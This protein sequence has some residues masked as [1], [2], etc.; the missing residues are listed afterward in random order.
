MSYSK[1]S[2]T[3]TKEL[4]GEEKKKNGIYFTPPKC[5]QNNMKEIKTYKQTLNKV[6]EPSC[7]SCEYIAE[8]KKEYKEANIT[9]IEYNKFIYDKI[10][11]NKNKQLNL[12]NEDFLEYKT[13]EKYDLIIGN[14]PYY[15]MKQS[16]KTKEYKDYFDG[17]PNIFILFIIKSLQL[18]SEDG[19]LSFVLPRNF[20]NCVYYNKTREYISNNYKILSIQS[21]EGD[22]I[23]TQQDTIIL[24]VQ[25]T[26]TEI[27]N[28]KYVKQIDKYTIFGTEVIIEKLNNLYMNSKTLKQL[29]FQ[30]KVGNVTWNDCKEEL[31]DDNTK[32][33]I[34]YNADIKNENTEA[35]EF[36]N[37]D[38]KNY[39]NRQGKKTPT[40]LVNRGYGVGKYT[41]DYCI[42]NLEKEYLLENHV[43]YIDTLKQESKEATLEKY[44]YI[45]KSFEDERTKDFINLYFGNNAINTKEL[46]NIMPIYNF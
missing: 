38:K 34:I 5:I 35:T 24:N 42:L 32:T 8:I 1:L 26:E 23:E 9:G 41:F 43:L 15:V 14:P 7:G 4:S 17:R 30:V 46:E 11:A 13:M 19:I 3:I 16:K 20:L 31:T 22:Y 2:Y 18:L 12:L 29:N 40:L 44:K 28:K 36:K 6:L 39:I 25:K 10:K 45:I 33:R 27:D 21:C 37:I